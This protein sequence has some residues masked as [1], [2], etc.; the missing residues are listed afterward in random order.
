MQTQPDIDYH[1]DEAKYR[2]RTARQLAANPD[3]V[4]QPLPEGFPAKV[5]GPIV[6]EG[7][8]WKGEHQWVY[9]LST[10]ELQEIDGAL[11]HFK[12]TLEMSPNRHYFDIDI[13]LFVFLTAL[14]TPLGFIGRGTFPLPTLSPKL[15]ELAQELYSGR[16]FFVLRE[17]PVDKYTREELAIVYAGTCIPISHSRIS[18]RVAT[19]DI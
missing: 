3:R 8:D 18:S 5:E 10:S 9:R 16:G 17:I 1:P 2:A 15:W 14:N 6:W 13:R 4:R 19:I 7:K 12:G 11:A